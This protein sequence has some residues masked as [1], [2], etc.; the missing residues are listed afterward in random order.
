MFN[1]EILGYVSGIM[2]SL[3]IV[4]QIYK[5]YISGSSKDLSTKMFI[6]QY[7]AYTFAIVYGI[8]IKH[9]AVYLMNAIGFLLFILLH[10]VKIYNEY[11]LNVQNT[12]NEMSTSSLHSQTELN[13]TS[14]TNNSV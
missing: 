8:L 6:I 11:Y 13:E 5:S 4:P 12:Y 10:S 1:P 3:S 14:V 2:G 7:I 9:A